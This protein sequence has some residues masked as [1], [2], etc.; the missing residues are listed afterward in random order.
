MGGNQAMYDS[1]VVMAK[2]AHLAQV[3]RS[4]KRVLRREIEKAVIEYEEEMIP[5]AFEWVKKSGGDDFVVSELSPDLEIL[6]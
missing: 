4:T 5:R 2:M 1:G 6:C 3:A